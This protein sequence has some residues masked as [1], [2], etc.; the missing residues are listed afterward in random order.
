MQQEVDDISNGLPLF[1]KDKWIGK[2]QKFLMN[3]MDVP[4]R[5]TYYI[6]KQLII[7]NEVKEEYIHSPNLSIEAFVT[8]KLPKLS[9]SLAIFKAQ[10]CFCKE[11]REWH[12]LPWGFPK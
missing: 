6:D 9:Y 3:L 12:G 8:Q 1:D 5:L 11:T 10:S 4:L 7:P 2:G